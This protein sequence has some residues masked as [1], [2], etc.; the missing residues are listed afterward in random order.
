MERLSGRPGR[1]VV[2]EPEEEVIIYDERESILSEKLAAMLR[3]SIQK[4]PNFQ[5]MH[6]K[7]LTNRAGRIEKAN[8]R[9]NKI[10]FERSRL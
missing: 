3:Q 7:N 1:W 2:E 10:F 8:K 9:L 5:T 6:T 4:D